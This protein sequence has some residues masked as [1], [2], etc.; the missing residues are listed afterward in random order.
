MLSEGW[1]ANNVTHILGLR[2]FS[3]QLLCEQVVGRGLRRRSYDVD[4]A[5]GLLKPE[6]VRVIG[7]PF[8]LLPHQEIDSEEDNG[9]T[10]P[11]APDIEIFAD[12]DKSEFQISWP[13]V[14]RID[15][16]MKDHLSLDLDQIDVL[17]LDGSKR[18]TS[19]NLGAT[20]DGN[21]DI[22]TMSTV[23]LFELASTYRT[24][25]IVFQ[26]VAEVLNSNDISQQPLWKSNKS[27]LIAQIVRFAYR[28]IRSNKIRII[29]EQYAED[30]QKRRLLIILSMNKIVR[31]FWEAIKSQSVEHLDITLN[32]NR[33]ISSTGDIRN[34]WTRRPTGEAPN[35]HINLCVVD[36][37]WERAAAKVLSEHKAVQAWVKNDHLGYYVNYM[38]KGKVRRY[39]PDFLIRLHNDEM[40]VLEIKGQPSEESDA[41]KAA[42]E[43][44]CRAV[45]YQVRFGKWH[46]AIAYSSMKTRYILDRFL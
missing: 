34:W 8:A 38:Y 35:S 23:D 2:P 31:H 21:P 15:S 24:Q 25:T 43:E 11:V 39:I 10:S 12:K 6:Y 13:N 9:P 44:W 37:S 45:N 46:S 40:L 27:Y 28:F 29:P 30:S 42:L 41:K 5:D 17:T 3:S 19:A 20:I 7:V 14:I 26:T 32:A 18:I 16:I 4:L 1:D 36:S 22:R 33:S